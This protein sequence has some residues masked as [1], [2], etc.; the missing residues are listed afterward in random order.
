[1]T[2]ATLREALEF[3]A[4]RIAEE[5]SRRQIPLSDQERRMF[6]SW[7]ENGSASNVGS[8]DTCRTDE[9]G[10]KLIEKISMLSKQ[11]YQRDREESS[12]TA[13]QWREAVR[14]LKRH[15][16][17][18]W[19]VL[20]IP[21]SAADIAMLIFA[22][23]VLVLLMLSVIAGLHWV[24]DHV[25]IRFSDTVYVIALIVSF[26]LLYYL[27]WSKTAKRLGNRMMNHL[28]DAVERVFRWF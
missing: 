13:R 5:A 27:T 4:S 14:V 6:V 3:L 10:E 18:L 21:R 26:A 8:A 22:A 25:H 11:A 20:Y 12:S 28:G 17:F 7:E 2:F 15:N 23:F 9:D 19:M 1:M 16:H 24:D